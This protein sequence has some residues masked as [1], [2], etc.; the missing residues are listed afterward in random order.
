MYVLHKY[1]FL[2][3]RLC[4]INYVCIE[5]IYKKECKISNEIEKAMVR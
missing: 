4:I 5:Q 2:K 1:T 3:K